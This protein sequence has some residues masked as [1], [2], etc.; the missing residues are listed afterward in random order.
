MVSTNIK[1]NVALEREVLSHTQDYCPRHSQRM[2][3][4]RDTY[5]FCAT[6][7]FLISISTCGSCSHTNMPFNGICVV[8]AVFLWY[9]VGECTLW[10][11]SATAA[12]YRN[13]W[14]PSPTCSSVVYR[15]VPASSLS[16]PSSLVCGQHLEVS[17]RLSVVRHHEISLW[18][19]YHREWIELDG[20]RV[21]CDAFLCHGD[22]DAARMRI[23]A[24]LCPHPLSRSCLFYSW[25]E[26]WPCM[27]ISSSCPC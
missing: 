17:Q 24:E 15:L 5:G 23:V 18:M 7:F 16:A 4:F 9:S 2:Y 6:L 14:L 21:E 22:F 10:F 12:R 8:I 3:M 19:W 1:E 13:G 25:T 26:A 11:P 27:E 20:M